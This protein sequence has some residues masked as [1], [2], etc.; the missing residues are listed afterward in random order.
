MV[1]GAAST[2]GVALLVG[3]GF[4]PAPTCWA[5]IFGFGRAHP[6]SPLTQAKGE[7]PRCVSE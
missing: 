5:V 3:A 2:R 7:I 1:G 4:K 6:P